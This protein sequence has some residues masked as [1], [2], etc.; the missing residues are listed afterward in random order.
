M[1]PKDQSKK[2]KKP[3]PDYP[4]G[5]HP[6]G[7]WCKKIRGRVHFFGVWSDPNGAVAK[8]L[9]E[10]DDL[11]AGRSPKRLSATTPD[12]ATLCNRF[13]EQAEAKVDAQ[14]LSPRTWVDY[15]ECCVHLL[16][17]MGR[18]TAIE[19]IR[20]LDFAKIR[21]AWA[22]KYAPVRLSKLVTMTR[23]IFNWGW[24]SDLF[25]VPVKFGP[26]F[27]GATKKQVRER[28][29][30]VGERLFSAADIHKLLNAT[31]PTMRA[32]ILLAV[33]GGLG[34]SDIAGLHKDHL[35]EPGWIVYPRS[36]TAIGRRIPLWPEAA[37]AI[38]ASPTRKP[39]SPNHAG[40]L[41][42]T[43]NRVPWVRT[44]IRSNDEV[45]KAFRKL[46]NSTEMYRK[47][48][49]F[50][51]L[52]HV[53]ATIADGARDPVAVSAILGH[54]DATMGAVY[55]EKVEDSRLLAVSEHVRLWLDWKPPDTKSAG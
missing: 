19:D 32:M 37:A 25:E 1:A 15:R 41:F 48:L 38:K 7:Q 24:E 4:L 9:A 26:D 46:L 2:P 54:A 11:Q 6:N 31:N 22:A 43:V 39:A 30:E 14:S 33:S 36:K 51:S 47:G 13:L 40:L 53:F 34:N 27:T 3:Y 18:T 28:R 35:R 55:R 17:A 5:P 50:Y 44:G 20:P 10:R 52:R 21:N 8:Y 12:L 23:T 49:S 42:L 45:T 29:N 16:D